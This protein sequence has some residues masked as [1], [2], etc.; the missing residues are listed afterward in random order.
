M[1]E[2]VDAGPLVRTQPVAELIG[3]N[4]ILKRSKRR[5]RL[6]V[7]FPHRLGQIGA[8]P[9]R[10]SQAGFGLLRLAIEDDLLKFL[11][12]FRLH[13]RDSTVGETLMR[14]A[15]LQQPP[16]FCRGQ[17]RLAAFVLEGKIHCQPI[18]AHWPN[19]DFGRDDFAFGEEGLQP[20]TQNHVPTVAPAGKY[21]GEKMSRFF[22]RRQREQ[23][24]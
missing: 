19:G 9:T 12:R 7:V 20:V 17:R 1:L 2:P 16:D 15:F 22:L 13:Q 14:P 24:G 4:D 8:E 3:E 10:D 23:P 5:G 21:V 11:G 6:P 18:I